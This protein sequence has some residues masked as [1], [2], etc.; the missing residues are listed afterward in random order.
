MNG[1]DFLLR[2]GRLI[3]LLALDLT[4]F[5][6]IAQQPQETFSHPPKAFSAEDDKFPHA[7]P[8]PDCVRRLL[9]NDEHVVDTLNY[10]H[11]SPE[12]LP[13][14]WF[15]ASERDLGQGN[16]TYVV[17]MGAG[18]MRGANI[19][20]FWV[21]Q[22]S[23]NSC[24][25]LLTVGAHDL[26]VLNTKTNGIPDIKIVALTAVRHFENQYR[27]DG[28]NYQVAKRVS[29]PIGEEIPRN[30]S[31]FETREPLIQR[32]GQSPDPILCEARA[33]LWQ[34]WWLEKSSYLKVT[35]HS[36][37]G[38]VTTTTYFIRKR[39]S[40]LQVVIHRHQILVDRIPHPGARNST[41]EDEIVIAAD[42]ERRLA[43]KDNPDRNM[44]VPEDQKAAPDSYELYF[45]DD[46]GDNLDVL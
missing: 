45:N 6:A 10:E 7:T 1:I 42:I 2:V 33:W 22:A 23:A 19:N 5:R 28:H 15:T 29:Q 21:F 17:V 44:K 38:D 27:F 41:V 3:L 35:L 25:L 20:P 37:E 11:L 4:A 30:L 26:E 24:N 46:S 36:K 32:A 34:Q 43:L 8:L 12:Q 40:D 16:G 13:A 39:G 31:D 18:L 14:D 9:A